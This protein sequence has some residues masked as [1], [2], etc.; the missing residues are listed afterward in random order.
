MAKHYESS[1]ETWTKWVQDL[2]I[3]T[4]TEKIEKTS[5]KKLKEN[6]DNKEY[7]ITEQMTNLPFELC[8]YSD[9]NIDLEINGI[10]IS[11]ITALVLKEKVVAEEILKLQLKEKSSFIQPKYVNRLTF[12]HLISSIE[13]IN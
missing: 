7:L 10:K 8:N 13:K 6:Y 4:I 3:K 5:F 12:Y 9:F 11:L 2:L 1:T